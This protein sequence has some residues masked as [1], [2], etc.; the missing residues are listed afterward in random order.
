M[1]NATTPEI[2]TVKIIIVSWEFVIVLRI[3]RIA[4]AVPVLEREIE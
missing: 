4:T 2:R 3:S 1:K